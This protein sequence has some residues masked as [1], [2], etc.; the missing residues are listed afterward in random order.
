ML[1]V[2]YTYV[3]YFCLRVWLSPFFFHYLTTF[4]SVDENFIYRVYFLP[5]LK[6][7]D[8]YKIYKRKKIKKKKT[9]KKT[10]LNLK[11]LWIRINGL[12]AR[13]RS[14]LLD[15]MMVKWLRPIYAIEI[16]HANMPHLSVQNILINLHFFFYLYFFG[17]WCSSSIFFSFRF[18]F[19]E[20][21]EKNY[22]S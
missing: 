9:L 13:Q 16:L 1:N 21:K 14:E 5:Q 4:P 20:R 3:S 22:N 17:V 12:T 6:Q 18:Y 2:G 11:G 7:R 10:K 19:I 8:S 15:K